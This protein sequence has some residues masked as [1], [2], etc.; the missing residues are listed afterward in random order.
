MTGFL[1]IV[2]GYLEFNTMIPQSY[3]IRTL[4]D[5]YNLPTFEQVKTAAV[6]MAE[7][8]I[9]TRMKNDLIA[10]IAKANGMEVQNGMAMKFPD[11]IEWIDDGKGE[12]RLELRE[13]DGTNVAELKWKMEAGK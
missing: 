10:E 9:S 2:H 1:I 13:H 7:M 12:V 4:A 3:T 8:I 6:E 11:S 5:I